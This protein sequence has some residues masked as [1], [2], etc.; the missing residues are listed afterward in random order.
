MGLFIPRIHT[1]NK[2]LNQTNTFGNKVR[3][4]G[5]KIKH[6]LYQMGN[7]IVIQNQEFNYKVTQLLA[8]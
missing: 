7:T 4:A 2:I 6:V 8:I 1:G 5:Y 3:K